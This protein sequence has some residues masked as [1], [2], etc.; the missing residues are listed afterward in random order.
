MLLTKATQ[1]AG[2]YVD[3]KHVESLL[4]EYKKQRWAQNTERLGKADS[5]SA[6][7]S[8]EELQQFIEEARLNGA[9]GIKMYFGVYSEETAKNPEY[10]GRQT[11]VLVATKVKE[12]EN[13][14]TFDKSIYVNRNG[15][16]EILAFN[17]AKLCPPNCGTG[18]GID[19]DNPAVLIDQAGEGM[20]VI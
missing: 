20:I 5:L 17:L 14:N 7:Y 13:G 1:K 15:R 12:M 16:P 4:A 11:N 6:W 3:S 10:V 18:T 19:V 2:Q 8:I 9:D